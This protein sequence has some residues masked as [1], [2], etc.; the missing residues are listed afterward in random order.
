MVSSWVKY[1]LK[2]TFNLNI[3][4]EITIFNE[5]YLIFLKF[6]NIDLIIQYKNLKKRE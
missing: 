4:D 2:I 1:V 3:S 6:F 5:M